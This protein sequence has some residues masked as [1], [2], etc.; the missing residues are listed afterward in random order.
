M[1]STYRVFCLGAVAV[2][3]I[4]TC[5]HA[6]FASKSG[7]GQGGEFH[8]A[9]PNNPTTTIPSDPDDVPPIDSDDQPDQP[10]DVPVN[11]LPPGACTEM[12]PNGKPYG[13]IDF[14]NVSV[15]VVDGNT[16]FWGTHGLKIVNSMR[17]LQ[18]TRLGDSQPSKDDQAWLCKKC[19]G[20]PSR[21][22]LMDSASEAIVGR[23]VLASTYPK[24]DIQT[25]QLIFAAPVASG[26]FDLID[27]DGS[28]DWIVTLYD[29][30]GVVL[31]AKKLSSVKGYKPSKT[32]N[33]KPTRLTISRP[34]ADISALRIDG[35][36]DGGYFGFALDNL[37]FKVCPEPVPVT[38]NL[39]K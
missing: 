30:S 7:K 4:S 21:N 25:F 17:V 13:V 3:L 10:T 29:A 16:K 26:S 20:K 37:E 5:K 27:S 12:G 38:P 23:N 2:A 35:H 1:I 31:E 14:E 32:S 28:E 24:A 22:R 34:T 33:G 9:D 39:P 6:D 8:G 15:G 11:P 19:A 36:K 18:T